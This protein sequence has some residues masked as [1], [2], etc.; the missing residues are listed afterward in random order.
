[1]RQERHTQGVE[2]GAK[3]SHSVETADAELARTLRKESI[4]L[5]RDFRTIDAHLETFGCTPDCP[6]CEAK[7]LGIP[8]RVH[9]RTCQLRIEAAL[10]ADNPEIPA[11]V[12]RDE[13]HVKW[14]EADAQMGGPEAP[15]AGPRRGGRDIEVEIDEDQEP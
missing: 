15:D 7:R 1:M 11:L 2:F 13:R 4:Q 12:R 5:S 10:R 8:K 6:R 3:L 14:A 9:S